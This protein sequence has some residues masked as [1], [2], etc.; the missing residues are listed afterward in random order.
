VSWRP[1]PALGA[2][3]QVA[4]LGDSLTVGVDEIG[5]VAVRL[6]SVGYGLAWVDAEVGRTTRQAVAALRTRRRSMPKV[7]VIGLGTNDVV[8]KLPLNRFAAQIDDM[9][10]IAGSGRSVIWL[11]VH[12]G[13]SNAEAR[14][15]R[16]LNDELLRAAVR[17]PNLRVADWDALVSHF[18]K[19]VDPDGVHLTTRGYELR[20]R[21]TASVVDELLGPRGVVRPLTTRSP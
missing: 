10:A 4:L 21:Y 15:T 9:M 13:R 6:S 8:D 16:A 18:P 19:L 1:Q 12:L 5:R 7:I 20:A 17:H 3:A 2:P 11:N 14:S